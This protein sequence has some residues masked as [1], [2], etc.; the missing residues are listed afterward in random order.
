MFQS[1]ENYFLWRFKDSSIDIKLKAKTLLYYMFVSAL[2]L[3][4]EVIAS[5]MRGFKAVDYI[6]RITLY[7]MLF[8]V[9]L[10]LRTGKYRA[11]SYAIVFGSHLPTLLFVYANRSGGS[12]TPMLFM[13]MVVLAALF[14]DVITIAVVSITSIIMIVVVL[15]QAALDPLVRSSQ[16]TVYAAVFSFVTFICI[17]IIRIMKKAI[18]DSLQKRQDMEDIMKNQDNLI[19]S[20][21]DMISRLAE[22]SNQINA[23]STQ[24]SDGANSQASNVEQ[25]S[26]SS[27]EMAAMVKQTAGNMR[28]TDSIAIETTRKAEEGGIVIGETIEAINKISKRIS[29]I[30]DIAYQTNLLALNAAIEAA[31]AGESGRGFAVVAGEVRKL[32]EKSQNASKEI[33]ELAQ[34]SVGVSGQA[35]V[36][37][38]DIFDSIRKTASLVQEVNSAT[39]ELDTGIEQVSAGMDQ[40]NQISQ[41]NAAISE[42]LSSLSTVL[43]KNA[44]EIQSVMKSLYRAD[45][46]GT[47]VV[48][49]E[50]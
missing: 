38:N 40:L 37:L 35:R 28:K 21:G 34:H 2:L 5:S 19:R 39:E 8:C 27:Q 42:E 15:S 26:S 50:S 31:R 30:E 6:F 43:N 41:N 7:I 4:P 13:V 18:S 36:L 47:A 9:L 29:I 1:L 49:K 33:S 3:I 23:T 11:A 17:L 25:I 12:V 48:V 10:L 20:M 14:S 46:T 22:A 24:L 32:A 44:A 45:N 16:I